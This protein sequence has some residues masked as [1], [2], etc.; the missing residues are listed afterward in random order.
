MPAPV[1]ARAAPDI[2]VVSVTLL[3]ELVAALITKAEKEAASSSSSLPMYTPELA[4][5]VV[6]QLA[7][8]AVVQ[9]QLN[10]ARRAVGAPIVPPPTA[11]PALLKSMVCS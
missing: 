9:S 11:A 6:E 10:K 3:D 7:T 5:A 4:Q 2:G 8:N 1:P